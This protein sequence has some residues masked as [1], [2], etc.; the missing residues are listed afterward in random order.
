MRFLCALAFI[1][2]PLSM[3]GAESIK[4]G[5]Q[6]NVVKETLNRFGYEVDARK[7]GFTIVASDKDSA[8]DF[9]H[10]D[11]D[12]TLVLTY[13][14]QTQKVSS[15]DLYFWPD[16]PKSKRQVI[17]RDV[18]EMHVEEDGVYTIKLK[19]KTEREKMRD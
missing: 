8:L 12:I 5:M 6:L 4:P 16:S 19:R 14:R 9:C 17:S 10:I 7:H 3:S 2:F 11:E 18:L 15:L 13:E 1:G